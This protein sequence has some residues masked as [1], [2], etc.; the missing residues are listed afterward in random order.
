LTTEVAKQNYAHYV[1]I[2]FLTNSH[3]RSVH[4]ASITPR[5]CIERTMS[6]DKDSISH[7]SIIDKR[8]SR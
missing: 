1:A 6:F 8:P 4:H 2:Y 7:E 3:L 5:Q